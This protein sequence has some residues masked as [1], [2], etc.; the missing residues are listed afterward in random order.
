VAQGDEVNETVNAYPLAWPAGWKR[1]AARKAPTFGTGNTGSRGLTLH[2]AAGRIF[3]ELCKLHVRDEDVVISTNVRPQLVSR[4]APEQMLDPGVAVY[5]IG[6]HKER[7]CI[8]I[9]RYNTVPGNLAA[10]AATLEAMR[11]IDRHGGAEILDR[12]FAGF[13]ALPSAESPWEILGCPASASREEI[14]TAF[15][16]ASMKAHPDRPGGST[17]AMQKLNRARDQMLEGLR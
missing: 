11:A 4:G 6:P 17:E 16:L 15:R 8:A 5:W 10:I 3:D 12:A 14:Q 1:C 9:D 13:V 7:R 2:Q